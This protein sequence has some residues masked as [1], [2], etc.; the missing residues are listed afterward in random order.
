VDVG[1]RLME[2]RFDSCREAVERALSVA[3]NI[4]WKWRSSCCGPISPSVAT[5]HLRCGWSPRQDVGRLVMIDVPTSHIYLSS[6]FKNNLIIKE[7][8]NKSS[9]S[10]MMMMIRL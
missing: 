10:L 4:K 9:I 7:S 1:R 6:I 8:S 2:R 3:Y 5:S